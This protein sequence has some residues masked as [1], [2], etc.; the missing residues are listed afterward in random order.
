MVTA[1]LQIE[2]KGIEVLHDEHCRQFLHLSKNDNCQK[3]VMR[4]KYFLEHFFQHFITSKSS[5]KGVRSFMQCLR[6]L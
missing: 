3:C 5:K 1:V 4:K 2:A 6:K